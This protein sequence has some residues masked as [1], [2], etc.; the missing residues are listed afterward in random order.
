MCLSETNHTPP[1]FTVP[2]HT[3]SKSQMSWWNFLKISHWK[4]S[5]GAKTPDQPMSLSV[6]QKLI[7]ILKYINEIKENKEPVTL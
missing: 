4:Q 7:Q 1:L 3:E 6:V 5:V 2:P